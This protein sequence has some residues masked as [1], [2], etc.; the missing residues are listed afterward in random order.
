MPKSYSADLRRRV[1]EAVE[2]GASLPEAAERGTTAANIDVSMSFFTYP[3]S[4]FARPGLVQGVVGESPEIIVDLIWTF[5]GVLDH[6][7]PHLAERGPGRDFRAH[8][9]VLSR[10]HVCH[11]HHIFQNAYAPPVKICRIGISECFGLFDFAEGHH[12]IGAAHIL[13]LP[14]RVCCCDRPHYATNS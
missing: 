5:L 9:W 12:E 10:Q 1:I 8:R 6:H 14:N 13:R 4:S 11:Q 3:C 2:A 7:I